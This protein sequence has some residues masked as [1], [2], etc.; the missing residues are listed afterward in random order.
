[1]CKWREGARRLYDF[2]RDC[3]ASYCPSWPW[4]RYTWSAASKAGSEMSRPVLESGH[5]LCLVE[6]AFRSHQSKAEVQKY[7][8]SIS[9]QKSFR[10]PPLSLDAFFSRRFPSFPLPAVVT[11]PVVAHMLRWPSQW[12]PIFTNLF[13]ESASRRLLETRVFQ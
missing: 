2:P 5:R 11:S 7:Y 10:I 3:W 1:M 4:R 6:K 12:C 8:Q 13:Q 9:S